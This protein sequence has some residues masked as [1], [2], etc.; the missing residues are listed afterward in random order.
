V[1]DGKLEELALARGDPHARRSAAAA[2]SATATPATAP[3]AGAAGRCF[4][5]TLQHP[6][7]RLVAQLGGASDDVV[8]STAQFHSLSRALAS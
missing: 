3:S 1:C 6:L 2:P 8:E 4:A 7:G 5:T